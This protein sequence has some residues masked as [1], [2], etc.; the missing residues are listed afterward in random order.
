LHLLIILAGHQA[1]KIANAINS[2]QDGF[3]VEYELRAS[4][5]ERGLDYQRVTLGPVEAIAGVEAHAAMIADRDEAKPVLL[6]LVIQS[7][8]AAGR[9][10][11][12]VGRFG[13]IRRGGAE[14]DRSVGP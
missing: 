13:L 3:S 14:R 6:H 8:C 10:A 12:R 5:A 11:G 4:N 9:D 7:G 1:F 2:E